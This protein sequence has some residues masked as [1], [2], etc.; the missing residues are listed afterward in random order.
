MLTTTT[1]MVGWRLLLMCTAF[2][3]LF[4]SGSRSL[5]CLHSNVAAANQNYYVN[6]YITFSI[7]MDIKHEVFVN[8]ENIRSNRNVFRIL[9]ICCVWLCVA[10]Y[11][12]LRACVHHFVELFIYNLPIL[13]FI[14]LSIPF[15]WSL[16]IRMEF[17]AHIIFI[18]DMRKGLPTSFLHLNDVNVCIAT[19]AAPPAVPPQCRGV[20]C[21]T[22]SVCTR[23]SIRKPFFVTCDGH[24]QRRRYISS[25]RICLDFNSIFLFPIRI[26]W[27]TRGHEPHRL[28]TI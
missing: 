7:V 12:C 13:Q 9:C 27:L 14:F 23:F 4:Q 28:Q 10:V 19:T 18:F 5:D 25:V 24:S 17:G 2:I 11:D 15:Y 21:E 16:A 26:L 20:E 8:V 1:T 22:C 6:A 3:Y